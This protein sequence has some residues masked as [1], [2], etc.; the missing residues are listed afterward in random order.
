MA[1]RSQQDLPDGY[2]GQWIIYR[3]C[4]A[5]ETAGTIAFHL[6]C[7]YHR[8]DASGVRPEDGAPQPVKY[9]ESYAR[10]RDAA[11]A[12]DMLTF[13]QSHP[14]MSVWASGALFAALHSTLA[15]SPAKTGLRAL[16]LPPRAYRLIYVALALA[17]TALWLG[18]VRG[19]PDTPLYRME[20]APRLAL[21]AV[22]AIGAILFWL[23]LRPIDVAAFLGLRAFRDGIEPFREDGIYRR[24]RHP[25]Y[26]AAMLV[27]FAHPEQGVNSL[28]LFACIALYFVLGSRL[29]ER[30][31]L[32]QHPEYAG[33]R[34]RV[35]AFL[36][37]VPWPGPQR[38]RNGR[39]DPR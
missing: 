15:A 25:M 5:R 14:V 24:L 12:I 38:P 18:F 31:M 13:I 28:N 20:G 3:T 16:G 9:S 23:A 8:V 1:G 39:K 29:E 22:Q 19:L 37:R 17:T 27:M 32:A 4:P 36:P 2:A 7:Q 34:R 10:A 26:A 21:H 35:P 6:C 11:G 30:R 33:Y